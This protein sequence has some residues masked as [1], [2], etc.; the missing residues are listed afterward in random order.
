MQFGI[1]I[2]GIK[3]SPV[4]YVYKQWAG[5]YKKGNQFLHVNRGLGILGFMGRVGMRPEITI[6]ELV[7]A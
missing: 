1:E 2:P 3:W 5:L 6:V 4:Q 7:K